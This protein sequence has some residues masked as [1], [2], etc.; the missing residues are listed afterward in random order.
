MLTLMTRSLLYAGAVDKDKLK[1]ALHDERGASSVA[2]TSQSA[3]SFV[4]QSS[5]PHHSSSMK[6][7]AVSSSVRICNGWNTSNSSLRPRIFCLEHAIEIEKL[8]GS[9]GGAN[10]LVICH[11]GK[12][13]FEFVNWKLCEIR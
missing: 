10:V 4:M 11:S 3:D 2:E 9:K 1:Q 13:R 6:Q 8:L 12:S 7:K 5:I